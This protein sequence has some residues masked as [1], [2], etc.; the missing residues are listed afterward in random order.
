MI[1][2]I[3]LWITYA[4]IEGYREA[5]YFFFRGNSYQYPQITNINPHTLFTTQRLIVGSMI[6]VAYYIF[7]SKIYVALLILLANGLL[8]SFFHDGMYYTIRNWISV[9]TTPTQLIYPK[10][11][12]DQSITS[13]ALEDKFS[14]SHP[15]SRTIQAII[16]VAIYIFCIYL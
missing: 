7:Y 15:I 5:F 3:L 6:S 11:W 13:T 14:I 2:T 12:F 4:I 8:F 16:G 9:K 10:K 1:F